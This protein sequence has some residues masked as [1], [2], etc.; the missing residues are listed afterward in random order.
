MG[1]RSYFSNCVNWPAAC[2]NEIGAPCLEALHRL[3]DKGVEITLADFRSGVDPEDYL[4]L[5]GDLNYARPGEAGMKIEDDWHVAFRRE[6]ETGILFVVHSAI[7][8][9]FASAEEVG[10]L[11]QTALDAEAG[12][13]E[14]PAA[15]VLVHAGSMCGSA[16]SQ[17]GK[18]EAD[19][20]RFDVIDEVAHHEGSLIVID[21]FLSD[22]LSP[23]EQAQIDAALARNATA[24]HL[25]LRLW[26]CD[27]GEAP[28]PAWQPFG[29]SMEGAVFDGQQEAATAV[30]PRLADMAITVTGAWATEDL[31]SGCA[32]S[33]VLALRA[34]L[35]DMAQVEHSEH[36]LFEPDD[37]YEDDVDVGCE[38]NDI[39]P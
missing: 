33:V 4:T 11:Q 9:V 5:L 39:E 18:P 29:A 30:A 28:Y 1:D 37:T 34:A 2:E 21:G 17:L 7:E 25:A 24:G 35:G 19:S 23:D 12:R 10:E 26:G 22:E 32:S 31:S 15:L 14:L 6:P 27:G 13:T 20:M 38:N 8:Y 36:V 16:R 3:I